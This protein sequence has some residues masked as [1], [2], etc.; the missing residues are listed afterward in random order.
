[1]SLS[2]SVHR[3]SSVFT[4]TENTPIYRIDSDATL[5]NAQLQLIMPET[6]WTASLWAK[7]LTNDEYTNSTFQ[8]GSAVNTVYNMPRTYGLSVTKKF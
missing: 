7:N 5:V 3:Q 6:G 4:N 2:G 8:N 1:M